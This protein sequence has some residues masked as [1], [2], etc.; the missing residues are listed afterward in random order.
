MSLTDRRFRDLLEAFR[1]PSPTP[2]GG[3][4]SALAGAVG[5][6][7]LAMVASLAKPRAEREDDLRRLRN[8]GARCT[9]LSV[10]LAELMDQ[11]AAAYDAVVAAF[12]LPKTTDDE[13]SSR[14]VRIQEA[15]RG[16]T[17]VPLEVMRAGADALGH[18][19]VVADFGNRHA[20][21]DVRVGLELLGAGVRGARLNVEINLESLKD[22]SY[23]TAAR[24]EAER[25][26]TAA[27]AR[28][29]PGGS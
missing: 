23:I 11:D 19:T 5:A 8:A 16:A 25:L 26:V 17:E 2:G 7:L 3:S 27:A 21:S 10:R 15:L 4:A 20:L 6:S 1:A 29:R 18:G 9:E 22:V 14:A 13:K 12:K 24:E 28:Q